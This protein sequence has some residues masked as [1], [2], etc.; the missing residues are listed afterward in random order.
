MDRPHVIVHNTASVDGRLTLAPG[1]LLIGGDPRWTAIAGSA[2]GYSRVMDQ[3]QPDAILEG[4]GS[5]V[6]EGT[7]LVRWEDLHRDDDVAGDHLPRAVVE[8]DGRKWFVVVDSESTWRPACL[9]L[10]E[11]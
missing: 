5:F 1:T 3:Y 4:S 9:L 6:A 8:V 10:T 2:D 11:A 7:E